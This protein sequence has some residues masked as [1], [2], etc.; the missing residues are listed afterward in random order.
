MSVRDEFAKHLRDLLQPLGQ[1]RLRRMF[2]GY[3][4]YADE[5][6]FAVIVD[7]QL[8]FKVDAVS[9]PLFEAAGLGEWIYVKDGKPV[10]MNYFRPPEDIFDDEEALLLWGPARWKPRSAHAA[11]PSRRS[12]VAAHLP[13]NPHDRQTA[14]PPRNRTAHHAPAQ[15]AAGTAGAALSGI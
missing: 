10:H 14:T 1:V 13:G 3:G 12:P 2:G 15:P 6:F 11:G 8:Y 5:L 7:Q 9:R 4:I